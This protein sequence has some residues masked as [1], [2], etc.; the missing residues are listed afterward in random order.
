MDLREFVE[1]A[2]LDVVSAVGSARNKALELGSIV[3]P[4]GVAFHG[5]AEGPAMKGIGV[6]AGW[7]TVQDVE[8]DVAV[9]AEKGTETG[10]KAGISVLSALLHLEAGGKSK[11]QDTMASRLSFSVPIALPAQKWT[12]NLIQKILAP[13]AE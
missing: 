13:P 3:N 4:N 6:G 1:T 12:P 10:A 9:T 7:V 8:F 11:Q 5:K 2:L